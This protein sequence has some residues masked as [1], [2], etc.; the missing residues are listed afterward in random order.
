MNTLTY[1]SYPVKLRKKVKTLSKHLFESLFSDEKGQKRLLSLSKKIIHK[2]ADI[3]GDS[4]S[5]HNAFQNLIEDIPAIRSQ[6]DLDAQAFELNDPAVKELA[7][8][9]LAYP[10]FYAISL[11]RLAHH[12]HLNK[13][14]F[15]PRLITEHAHSFTGIDIHPGAQIGNSFF[16]DHGTGVVIGE[17][18]V[19]GDNVSIYQGVTLGG[20]K[21]AKNLASTKRH[22]TIEDNVTLYANATVLGGDVAIGANSVIGANVCIT[23]S[24]PNNSVVTQKKETIIKTKQ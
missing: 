3:F 24:V 5:V 10:G 7:E 9:Y 2:Y 8:V 19:I 16:I 21:V 1:K 15:L 17:T 14:R 22:P 6:L 11:Y 4:L 23:E 18:T 13:V 20:I 12:L